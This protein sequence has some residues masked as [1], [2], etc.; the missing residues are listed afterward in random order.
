MSVGAPPEVADLRHF[1]LPGFLAF[2]EVFAISFRLLK[3]IFSLLISP[4]S[5]AVPVVS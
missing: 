5:L 1:L 3:S 2:G 4:V